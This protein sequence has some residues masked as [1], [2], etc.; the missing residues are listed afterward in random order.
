L[1]LTCT[2]SYNSCSFSPELDMNDFDLLINM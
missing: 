2:S 1:L